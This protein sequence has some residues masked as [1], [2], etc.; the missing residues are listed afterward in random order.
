[1]VNHLRELVALLQE[2]IA[3]RWLFFANKNL[4]LE[5]DYFGGNLSRDSDFLKR[6]ELKAI[7]IYCGL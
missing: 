2:K 4:G 7:R 5:G 6:C 1:M 3:N